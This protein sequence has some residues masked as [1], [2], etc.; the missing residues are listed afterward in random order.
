MPPHGVVVPP[1][2]FDDDA[3][4]VARAEPLDAQALVPDP[5]IEA[6]IRAVLPRL[7]GIDQR[8]IDARSAM[9]LFLMGLALEE[10]SSQELLD[11]RNPAG[12]SDGVEVKAPG[13]DDDLG[14]GA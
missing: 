11:R 9:R 12:Q 13:F 7:A 10:P 2:G 4:L 14:L 1:P 8:C 6:L 3:R 5:A